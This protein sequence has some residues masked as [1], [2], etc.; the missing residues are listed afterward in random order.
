MNKITGI[1]F[2]MDNTLLCSKIDFI[3]MK[4]ETFHF[5]VTRGLL[6]VELNLTNHTT[7]TLIEEAVTT[8]RLTKEMLEELWEIPKKYEVIGMN[9][10]K[11]EPGVVEV[12]EQLKSKYRLVV[13]TNNAVEA[14]EA[15][16]KDNHIYDYFDCIVGRE[17]VGAL[18]PSP[19]GFLYILKQYSTTTALDWISVGD[20]WIDGKAS[21]E[22]GIQF[23]SYHGDI[24]KM[25][26]MGV[27][28]S[29][30]LMDIRELLQYV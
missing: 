26:S 16:L 7:S 6:P 23:I 22:A 28:P 17:M 15:A 25:N 13:V 18:K 14:A 8:N 11:L 5:L 24:V 1:I 21:S 30:E 9:N 10:S 20:S 12:L 29:A 3:G 2:D 19:D 27:V 4:K